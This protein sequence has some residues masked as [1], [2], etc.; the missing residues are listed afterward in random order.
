MV[1]TELSVPGPLIIVD[2]ERAVAEMARQFMAKQSRVVI[3]S[4][5]ELPG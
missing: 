5:R 4:R 1:K 2:M 3:V